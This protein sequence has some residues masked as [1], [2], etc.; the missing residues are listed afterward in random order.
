MSLA[1]RTN[2]AVAL[3]LL[4][5]FVVVVLPGPAGAAHLLLLGTLA[6]KVGGTVEDGTTAEQAARYFKVTD[7]STGT[8]AYLAALGDKLY[9]VSRVVGAATPA[10]L[11]VPSVLRAI[12]EQSQALAAGQVVHLA[13]QA[14]EGKGPFNQVWP[15][16]HARMGSNY[17]PRWSDREQRTKMHHGIDMCIGTGEPIRATGNGKV[18]WAGEKGAYGNLVRIEHTDGTVTSYGHC[19]RIDVSVG[20]TVR[21]GETIALVGDTGNSDCPHLHFEVKRNGSTEDPR[22]WFDFPKKGSRF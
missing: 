8:V 10:W 9:L 22:R 4:P 14:A 7:T 20:Q 2:R 18:V 12:V 16:A 13:R 5:C 11:P 3:L 17:G 21:A 6:E 15:L 19:S 1:A